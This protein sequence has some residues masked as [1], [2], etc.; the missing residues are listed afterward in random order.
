M[1]HLSRAIKV[2]SKAYM[3]YDQSKMG[4]LIR[5]LVV[6]VFCTLWAFLNHL[7]FKQFAWVLGGMIANRKKVQNKFRRQNLN[8]DLDNTLCGI[9]TA[10][11]A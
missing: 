10:R 6:S 4:K 5:H 3:M 7:N 9:G 2:Q 1:T 11:A 8:F